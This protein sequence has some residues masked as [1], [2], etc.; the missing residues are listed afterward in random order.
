M[1]LV[2]LVGRYGTP[3]ARV[4]PEAVAK[5]AGTLSFFVVQFVGNVMGLALLIFGVI[6]LTVYLANTR[7]RRPAMAAMVFSILGIAPA[8]SALDVCCVG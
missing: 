5:T 4:A 2:A 3:N 1:T 8:L 6:S 7:A